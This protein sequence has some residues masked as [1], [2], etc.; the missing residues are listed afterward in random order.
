MHG[1]RSVR[2]MSVCARSER[3]PGPQR[4]IVQRAWAETDDG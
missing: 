4:Q 1:W 2:K 3:L